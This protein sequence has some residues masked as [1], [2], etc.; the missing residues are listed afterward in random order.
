MPRRRHSGFATPAAA[1]PRRP[2]LD[3]VPEIEPASHDG[4][5]TA[6]LET[7]RWAGV[8]FPSDSLIGK[9]LADGSFN[10]MMKL[11]TVNDLI[12]RGPAGMGTPLITGPASWD[13]RKLN[14]PPLLR[15][16]CL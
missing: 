3:T 4:P 2:L 14:R 16:A 12:T 9:K 6:L 1:P 11:P 8:H 7:A 10:I 15:S 5:I 13:M